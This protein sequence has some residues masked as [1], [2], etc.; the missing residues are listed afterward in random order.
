MACP[1]I[2]ASVFLN[3]DLIPEL[4]EGCTDLKLKLSGKERVK[5]LCD[6]APL[7]L[8]QTQGKL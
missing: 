2:W 4:K 5:L 3:L 6:E 7:A 1:V 8:T